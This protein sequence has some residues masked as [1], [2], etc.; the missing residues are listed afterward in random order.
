MCVALLATAGLAS[1]SVPGVALAAATPAA[2]N[3]LLSPL[4]GPIHGMGLIPT[5]PAKP[6]VTALARLRRA[7]VSLPSSVSLTQYAQPVGNQGEVGSCAAWSSD[8]GAIGYWEN[9]QGIAGGG[10]EPMYTYSQ[11]DG[12]QDNG[13]SIEGN[14]QIA[15]EQGVDTQSDYWQ[16]N[17]DWKDT[18]TTAERAHAVNWKL[19]GYHDLA[20]EPGGS[21]TVTQRAIETT[22]AEG[23]PVVIGIP[24]Y[25]NFFYI[26]SPEEGFYARASGPLEGYHAIVALGYDSRGLVIE[27]SW[28]TGWGASG[29]AKLSWSFINQ[30]VFDAVAVGPL[31]SG[32]PVASAAPV[33]SGTAAEGQTL[34]ASTGTWSPAPTAYAYQW[35]RSANPSSGWVAIA[36]ASSPAYVPV[37]ADAS[38]YLRVLVTATRSGQSGA[39]VSAALGPVAS[40][41]P[42][43]KTAPSISGTAARGSTLSASPGTWTPA[44][45][46]Y[47][48]QWQRSAN[49]GST[50]TKIAGAT[51][52]TYTLA[53]ADEKDQID[54]VVSAT[55][56]HGS[57]AAQ[58][59]AVGPVKSSPPA[60]SAAP[61]VSGTARVGSSLSAT[62]GVWSG[63]GNSYSYQWQHSSGTW[64]N[65]AGA[66]GSTYRLASGDSRDTVRVVVTA[67]NPDGS[68]Q[69]QSA[70][71]VSVAS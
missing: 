16:G 61:S 18:P 53:V 68:A 55:N 4:A 43:S 21:S 10:L 1:C 9:K 62:S 23:T 26:G 47:A 63:A 66:T 34:S 30:Y 56:S 48:Y 27:N 33:L 37:A 67:S 20:I 8:Y 11:V 45:T 50:W 60:V 3:Q 28:G 35:Q 22:L 52:A 71:T 69:A 14:L 70:A 38:Q 13:S 39:A 57:A 17:F 58:S 64:S 29:Y 25:E 42:V 31:V 46:S 12:G 40:G 44:G 59:A 24:V 6:S 32:Q 36:G 15:Q 49:G 41:A 19:T 54:V 51:A 7:A 2:S 65:I 5:T